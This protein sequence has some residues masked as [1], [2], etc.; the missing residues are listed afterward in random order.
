MNSM[1]HSEKMDDILSRAECV[2]GL[3]KRLD[4]GYDTSSQKRDIH[5]LKTNGVINK[6]KIANVTKMICDE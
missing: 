6:K 2:M 4:T 5:S 1:K 3:N